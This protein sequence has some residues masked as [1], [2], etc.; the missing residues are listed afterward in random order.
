MLSINNHIT[1]NHS[2]QAISKNLT[3]QLIF[4]RTMLAS[5]ATTKASSQMILCSENHQTLSIY[6]IIPRNQFHRFVRLLF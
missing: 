6:I 1:K 4:I 2:V 3:F 5:A